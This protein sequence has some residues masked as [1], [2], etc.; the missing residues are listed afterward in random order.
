MFAQT[1]ETEIII[2]SDTCYVLFTTYIVAN[3]NFIQALLRVHPSFCPEAIRFLSI[4]NR[5]G[6]SLRKA[7]IKFKLTTK[8]LEQKT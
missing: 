7:S 8:H 5:Q 6:H 3:V 1:Y 4:Y 2:Y